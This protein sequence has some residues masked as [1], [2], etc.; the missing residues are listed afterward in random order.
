MSRCACTP[1]RWLFLAS[2]DPDR[3]IAGRFDAV[4]ADLD[5]PLD[6]VLAVGH[7]IRL[8]G[9]VVIAQGEV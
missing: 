3:E 6:D 9:G 7:G 8:E 4:H 5:A 1:R 2:D